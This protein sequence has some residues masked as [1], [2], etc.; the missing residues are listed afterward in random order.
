M[1][2]YR[3]AQPVTGETAI[4]GFVD[5][6]NNLM[7]FSIGSDGNVFCIFPDVGSST[8]WSQQ[9]LSFLAHQTDGS[10]AKILSAGRD[11]SG[12]TIV[13]V[14]DT[15]D[16][17]HMCRL[18]YGSQGIIGGAERNV[19]VPSQWTDLPDK[20]LDPA[21]T[22]TIKQIKLGSDKD[23]NLLLTVRKRSTYKGRSSDNLYWIDYA[24][25]GNPSQEI[26][27]PSDGSSP[28]PF[29][30]LTDYRIVTHPP[31]G[32]PVGSNGVSIYMV[33]KCL[34]NPAEPKSPYANNLRIAAWPDATGANAA[35]SLY[36]G[37]E[38]QHDNTFWKISSV[39][40]TPAGQTGVFAI[41]QPD[42]SDPSNGTLVYCPLPPNANHKVVP[43]GKEGKFH[44]FRASRD[45]NG[46]TE[47][48][49]LTASN[50]LFHVR[51]HPP[52]QPVDLDR[53]HDLPF[54]PSDWQAGIEIMTQLQLTQLSVIRDHEGVSHVFVVAADGALHHIWQDKDSTDWH[55]EEVELQTEGA[56]RV[57]QFS[58]Y[59]TEIT[60]YDSQK[61]ASA[62][63]QVKIFSD[64]EVFIN[65]N[66]A[67]VVVRPDMPW[68]GTSNMNGQV[69]VSLKTRSLGTQALTVWTEF[70]PEADRVAIDPSGSIQTRLE[71][72][73]KSTD[74]ADADTL[75]N[76]KVTDDQ[77]NQT[78]LLKD[79]PGERPQDIA[80]ALTSAIHQAMSLARKQPVA[81]TETA[82]YL[83]PKTNFHVARYIPGHDGAYPN[84]IHT[85]AVAEQH[86]QLNCSSGKPVFRT[87]NRDEAVDLI[88]GKNAARS[89]SAVRGF[90]LDIDLDW[91]DIVNA[92]DEGVAAVASDVREIVVSTIID[93][94]TN[95]VTQINA[96]IEVL[97]NE[98][99]YVWNGVIE[100][101]EQAYDI[102]VMV[103]NMVG[104]AFDDLFRWLGFI[105][106]W[107]D[108]LRTRDAVKHCVNQSFDVVEGALQYVKSNSDT[109][110]TKLKSDVGDALD[111][112]IS[113]Q[114][115]S[116]SFLALQS[117]GEQQKPVGADESATGNVFWSGLTNNMG[118]SAP[119]KLSAVVPS[120]PFQE[121]NE[122]LTEYATVF[123]NQSAFSDA[124]NYFQEAAN[125]LETD[126]DY[127]LK[128]T[129]AGVLKTLQGLAVL[130]LE[131]IRQIVNAL[132]DAFAAMIDA[133]KGVLNAPW[134][135]PFVSDLYSHVTNGSQL[136]AL[137]LTSLIIAVPATAFYKIT[138]QRA[139]FP[140]QATVDRFKSTL[141]AQAMMRAAGLNPASN[142]PA[143]RSKDEETLPA[144]MKYFLG[145][146]ACINLWSYIAY[147]G[148]TGI[149]D[150]QPFSTEDA[151]ATIVE[152][153]VSI[154]AIAAEAVI[155]TVNFPWFFNTETPEF[156]TPTGA[157]NAVW[158]FLS[159]AFLSDCG[160][161]GFT[162]SKPGKKLMGKKASL[163]G[164]VGVVINIVLGVTYFSVFAILAK[165]QIEHNEPNYVVTEANMFAAAP[166]FFKFLRLSP[167][168]NNKKC[169]G[170]LSGLDL[171]CN[172]IAGVLYFKDTLDK[173]LNSPTQRSDGASAS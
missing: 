133:I 36:Y 41:Q 23:A 51:Q 146:M 96:R 59:W 16:R 137:D 134:D 163:F 66:G 114:I 120:G 145:S 93:P 27:H 125:K 43:I 14:C 169:Q 2:D 131:A 147:A 15:N 84:L 160:V 172:L 37:P 10:K 161:F 85:A 154:M 117:E 157:N 170:A 127:A 54:A 28:V 140:D 158:L 136:T 128:L 101:V 24:N 139:P 74:N 8:G 55:I 34:S 81:T 132:F 112:L 100:F 77:G 88:A 148:A 138:Y 153:V 143:P 18:L 25:P 108:I 44:S 113:S 79:E 20:S 39:P 65:V 164:N 144:E 12:D 47:V 9:N 122:R 45:A 50:T 56:Q 115:G 130:G 162:L 156:T 71:N 60:V 62:N 165:I 30:T 111:N 150:F 107:P 124:Q 49:A 3:I 149:A 22:V 141:T 98:L 17:M 68:T 103:F 46:L 105:F 6:N 95:L 87:L 89:D 155:L 166:L 67:M 119:P 82:R 102:V 129:L 70:M 29:R 63:R 167:W 5:S 72:L 110:F 159:L 83:H 53:P 19:I 42:S 78:P 135:I 75:L 26:S 116:E 121:L 90:G 4:A 7:I 151:P 80:D 21:I 91:G 171:S 31:A 48:F 106:N 32:V 104:V 11:K 57:E 76:A 94:V 118:D 33:G 142:L 38:E 92:V 99:H 13:F 126:P 152:G 40:D 64:N 173:I 109:F 168:A 1:Q 61:V 69:I 86:W 58:S 73:Q 97:I 35:T 52:Q 123:Q